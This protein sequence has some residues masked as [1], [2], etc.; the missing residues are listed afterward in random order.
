MRSILSL[1]P[2]LQHPLIIVI[3][4]IALQHRWPVNLRSCVAKAQVIDSNKP[5]VMHHFMNHIHLFDSLPCSL[6]EW[7]PQSD[8]HQ[9]GY[10][11]LAYNMNKELCTIQPNKSVIESQR[12]DTLMT[13]Q[14]LRVPMWRLP[15]GKKPSPAC[16]QSWAITPPGS[17]ARYWKDDYGC[18]R[19]KDCHGIGMV[20]S[21]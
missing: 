17:P 6:Y 5:A 4:T 12:F 2:R 11:T 18:Q 1:P 3:R 14:W 8:N 15:F 13:H 9:P 19:S 10:G 20:R 7:H 16:S 21:I